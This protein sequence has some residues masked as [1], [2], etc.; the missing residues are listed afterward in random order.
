MINNLE[1]RPLRQSDYK[2]VKTFRDFICE[3]IDE[4]VYLIINKKPTMEEQRKWVRE[5]L[6][7]IKQNKVILLTA[8]DGKK[9]VGNCEASKGRWKNERNVSIGIAILKKYRRKGLGERLLRM[10][11]NLAKKRFR[12]KN[13]YLNVAAPNKPAIGLYKKIGFGMLARFP[14]WSNHGGKYIDT[15]YMLLKK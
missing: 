10:T 13:T 3:L 9:T 7:G 14:R 6:A 5:K 4:N 12:P 15:L 2:N 1:I 11:I 8:W